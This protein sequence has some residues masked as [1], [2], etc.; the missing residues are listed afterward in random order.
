MK[1]EVEKELT[2]AFVAEVRKCGKDGDE[3]FVRSCV[4]SGVRLSLGASPCVAEA[5][6]GMAEADVAD[7][8]AAAARAEG[9]P[10]AR[11]R[12]LRL[13]A[14]WKGSPSAQ[15]EMGEFFRGGTGEGG[16]QQAGDEALSRYWFGKSAA[17]RRGL[18]KAAQDDAENVGA[19]AEGDQLRNERERARRIEEKLREHPYSVV[20]HL[21]LAKCYER[22]GGDCLRLALEHYHDA[23]DF[24]YQSA[25]ESIA[26]VEARIAAESVGQISP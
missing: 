24:G 26:R 8:V 12:L 25:C 3:A 7:R 23:V 11:R 4:R 15:D 21:A 19:N 17:N 20:V 10:E 9:V 2:E 16:R 14:A 1:V 6:D 13:Y 5:P 22:C 18:R